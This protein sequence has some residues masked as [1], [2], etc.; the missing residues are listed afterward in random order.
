MM[1]R[2]MTACCGVLHG[3]TKAAPFCCRRVAFTIHPALVT[4]LT[5]FVVSSE[6]L[7][8]RLAAASLFSL[9][10]KLCGFCSANP[11]NFRTPRRFHADSAPL[12]LGGLCVFNAFW[13]RPKAAL[14][15]CVFF[16]RI[17]SLTRR[18]GGAEDAEGETCRRMI[19]HTP[20]PRIRGR[21]VC[22]G[23]VKCGAV[24]G[25]LPNGCHSLRSDPFLPMATGGVAQRTGYHALMPS[26]SRRCAAE[27]GLRQSIAGSDPSA[28]S[29]CNLLHH[30]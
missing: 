28:P 9:F 22:A 24:K 6:C 16:H 14:C 30:I 11:D 23:V 26:A 17:R 10:L 20:L 25:V 19:F 29:R 1:P 2:T 21:F 15:L 27:C 7:R 18:R 13:L 4:E 8:A 5:A 12:R 3:V